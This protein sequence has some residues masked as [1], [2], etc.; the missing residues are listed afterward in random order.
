LLCVENM[1][2][3]TPVATYLDQTCNT[4]GF[5][6]TTVEMPEVNTWKG[7]SDKIECCMCEKQF[8]YL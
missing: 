5:N 1:E 2:F 8:V 3:A 4:C 6:A 7:C